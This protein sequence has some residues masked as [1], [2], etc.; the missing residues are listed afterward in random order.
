MNDPLQMLMQGILSASPNAISSP[1]SAAGPT[2]SDLPDGQTTGLCGQA[3]P[4]ASHSP[5]QVLDLRPTTP[6]TSPPSLSTWSGPAAPQCCLANRSRARQCSDEFQASLN[7]LAE[8]RSGLGSTI[9]KT[10]WKQHTT[11]LGRSISRLRA[12]APRTS[13]KEPGSGRKGW[14]SPTA[15]DGSK[16]GKD[17]RPH[18][19]GVP[20]SQQAALS[21]WHTPMAR[22]GDKL[23]AT[24]PAIFKRMRDGREIGTA[25]QARLAGWPTPQAG[26]PAQNGNNEAGN[27]DSSRKTVAQAKTVGPAR[28]TSSGEMLTGCSAG[29]ESG[30]QLN[31]EFSRWLQGYPAEW[32]SCGDTAM[33][34]FLK[35]PRS[36]S[37]SRKKL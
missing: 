5:Q 9:Y 37:A 18:D 14:V 11:P 6:D 22:D 1:G 15:Q 10:V 23:D 13:G 17:A 26:T 31:P 30:G 33:R 29:M 8:R 35:S 28:L 34:S 3:A 4:H 16:G 12:S 27:T 2:P 32:G 19:T 25:M 36:S 24:L 20:L 21:G 7:D